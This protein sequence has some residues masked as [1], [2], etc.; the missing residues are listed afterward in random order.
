MEIWFEWLKY[1]IS[2]ILS[3]EEFLLGDK[4][5][6]LFCEGGW[7]IGR[8]SKA[9]WEKYIRHAKHGNLFLK[10]CFEKTRGVNLFVEVYSIGQEVLIIPRSIIL[11]MRN[12]IKGHI[13]EEGH[14]VG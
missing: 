9:S 2:R 7:N 14:L 6:F 10:R 8:P 1:R 5:S 11:Q 12:V 13:G 4:D 3:L